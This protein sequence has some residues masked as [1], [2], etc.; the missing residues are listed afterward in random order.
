[1]EILV[2]L[3]GW[4]AYASVFIGFIKSYLTVNKI[5]SRKHDK[6]VAESI[7]VYAALLGLV[8]ALPFFIKYLIIDQDYASALQTGVGLLVGS[9][10]LMVGIGFWTKQK[11]GQGSFWRKLLNAIKKENN[12]ATDLLKALVKPKHVERISKIFTQLVLIDGKI[13]QKERDLLSTF[14]KLWKLDV[15]IDEIQSE[16]SGVSFIQLRDSVVDYLDYAP[17]IEQATEVKDLLE[18]IANVDD[19]FSEDEQF[20]L[21]EI[22][23]VF[24]DY[25][26]G[27]DDLPKYEVLIAPQNQDQQDMIEH[28]V[29]ALTKLTDKGGVCYKV[30]EYYSLD[31]A[32]M[33]CKKYRSMN[34]FTAIEQVS[35]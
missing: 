34:I 1:M 12:E 3:V 15:N 22:Y 13:D 23:G 18:T 35:H 33:I 6:N 32:Q 2:L 25:L 17:P 11:K 30:G 7:S 21:K 19:H 26:N 28:L 20:I 16:S 10:F 4:F 27:D 5:W 9:F 14:H 24:D 29:K 8:S 31:Y